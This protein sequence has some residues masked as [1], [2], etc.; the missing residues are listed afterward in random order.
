[1][2][3]RQKYELLYIIPSKYT[4]DEV[5]SIMDKV[6]GDIESASGK[7]EEMHNLG[8]RRLAYPV[9]HVR[10][11]NYVLVWFEAETEKLAKLN[12]TMRLDVQI[13]RHLITM[14]N[15]LIKGLPNFE[16]EEKR[17]EREE[18]PAK[19]A[20]HPQSRPRK[21]APVNIE[22]LD[23]KLDKILNEEVE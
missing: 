11:G 6:K 10:F 13:L 3:K 14:R 15:L 12:E 23:K 18:R 16:E 20:G 4:E 5:K 17:E 7:V 1:M 2:E 22:E 21:E 8:K 19:S 9:K